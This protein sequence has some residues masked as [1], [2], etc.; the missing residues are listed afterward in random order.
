[1]KKDSL[2]DSPKAS[3]D[4]FSWI[5]GHWR[6]EAFGGQTEEVWTPPIGGSMMCAFKLSHGNEVSFYELCVM[7]EIEETVLLQLKH[8]GK[9]LK[10]WEEKDDTVDF[11]LVK[12][13]KDK[14]FFDQFTFERINEDEMH[15]YVVIGDK[16]EQPEEI[17]FIYKRFK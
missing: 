9:D 12:V 4:Q 10:G 16:N 15:I 14:A 3:I 7:R 13:T 17:Q 5:A 1:M 11:P 2:Q 6:G 8:F